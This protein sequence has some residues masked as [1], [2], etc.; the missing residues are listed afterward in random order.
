MTVLKQRNSAAGTAGSRGF[1]LDGEITHEIK[2]AGREE[3]ASEREV[4]AGPG[5]TGGGEEDPGCTGQSRAREGRADSVFKTE[6]AACG[7][8]CTARRGTRLW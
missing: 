3:K 7:R 4:T 6:L 5:W 2:P 1:G 8:D